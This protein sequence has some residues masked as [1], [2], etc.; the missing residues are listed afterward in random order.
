MPS[1]AGRDS[2]LYASLGHRYEARQWLAA[3]RNPSAL[4]SN[5]FATTAAG[6]AFVDSLYRLGAA[7]VEVT[8][9]QEESSRLRED[10]GPYS[11]ALLV[12]LPADKRQRAALFAVNAAEA[13]RE[14]FDAEPD[15]GQ[16]LL[17][18]WWD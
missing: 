2:A 1:D 3:N 16:T 17:Y 5:R 13:R 10:G 11:D 7:K 8:N 6:R 18:F 9:V 12:T 15:R 14:G 4:A